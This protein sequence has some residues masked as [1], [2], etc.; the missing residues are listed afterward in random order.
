MSEIS[1]NFKEDFIEIKEAGK[2]SYGVVY[3]ARRKYDNHIYAV[4]CTKFNDWM[5]I[6]KGEK[7]GVSLFK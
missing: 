2:G 4:K 1:S 5:E 7:I 3:K 6:A